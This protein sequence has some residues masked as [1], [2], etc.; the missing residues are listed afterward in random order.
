PAVADISRLERRS[1]PALLTV[2]VYACGANESV[3][4]AVGAVGAVE[5]ACDAALGLAG[6]DACQH[7]CALLRGQ[8]R[9]RLL[10]EGPTCDERV[11]VARSQGKRELREAGSGSGRDA[12]REEEE[13]S[14]E[15]TGTGQDF[16]AEAGYGLKEAVPVWSAPL[17]SAIDVTL[18]R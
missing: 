11:R 13:V 12:G 3:D 9:L 10:G 18:E 14:G 8:E 17:G 4:R 15:T 2:T 5:V 16:G 7:P 1:W 6:C